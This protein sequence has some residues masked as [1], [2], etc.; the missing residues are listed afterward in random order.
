MYLNNQTIPQQQV[1]GRVKAGDRTAC[2]T[3]YRREK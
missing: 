1:G 2:T 3:I